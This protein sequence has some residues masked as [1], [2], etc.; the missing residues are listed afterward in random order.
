MQIA[1]ESIPQQSLCD[2]NIKQWTFFSVDIFILQQIFTSQHKYTV[3]KVDT[4]LSQGGKSVCVCVY[5]L[6]VFSADIYLRQAEWLS[7]MTAKR[8][9]VHM[10]ECRGD[11]DYT[12]S[13]AHTHSDKESR[14]D[15]DLDTRMPKI[16][17]EKTKNFFFK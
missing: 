3:Q 14:V 15:P 13:R 11:D 5:F 6:F 8:L 16:C 2:L 9:A 17:L 12:L 10:D 7:T 1:R 4:Q